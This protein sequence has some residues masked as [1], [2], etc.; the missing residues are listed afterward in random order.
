[1]ELSLVGRRRAWGTWFRATADNN[2]FSTYYADAG[3]SRALNRHVSI[4]VD[5][6][7]NRY[8]FE[9]TATL[10]PPGYHNDFNR[11]SVRATLNAWLP[12]F[13]RGRRGNAAR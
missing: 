1:M 12:L 5:Y 10:L 2:G 11:N 7:F 4:A 8:E 6:S 3:V 13:Q 9:E